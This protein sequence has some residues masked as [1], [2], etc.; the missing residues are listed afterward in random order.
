MAHRI[1]KTHSSL[2]RSR[3]VAIVGAL[4][5]AGSVAFV[6]V[7][8]RAA[9]T[10]TPNAVVTWNVHAQTAIYDVARQSPTA[11]ARSVAMVQGAVYDAVNAIEGTPYEPYLVAA[12]S[13]RGDSA[14]AA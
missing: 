7:P 1:E 6:A 10:S 2:R 3:R 4:A 14:P 12:R 13:R 11:A 5:L 9:P 8:A